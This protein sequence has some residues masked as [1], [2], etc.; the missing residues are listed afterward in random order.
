MPRLTLYYL[1]RVKLDEAL[2]VTDAIK[3]DPVFHGDADRCPLCGGFTSMLPWLPPRR[4]E[5]EI[6]GGYADIAFPTGNN[7]LVSERFKCL[8]ELTDL[9]GLN[10]FEPV[11]I[12]GVVWRRGSRKHAGDV[13]KYFYVRV[14]RS[15]A[16]IDRAGSGIEMTIPGPVC[17]ECCLSNRGVLKRQASLVLMP[18]PKPFEDIFFARGAVGPLT[19]ERF[20]EFYHRHAITGARL[21]E[22]SQYSIDYYLNEG[23]D[24]E[25]S[26]A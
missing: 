9:I 15:R 1:D 4:A 10:G 20:Y 17:P 8:Y 7:M 21:I 2:V 14:S 16:R 3:D 5:L 23:R 11:E 19:S 26:G 12:T 24:Q 25:E 6:W 18:E 22:A 13:P